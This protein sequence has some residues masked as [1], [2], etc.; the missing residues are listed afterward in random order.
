VGRSRKQG[1]A[2]IGAALAGAAL[3]LPAPASAASACASAG[4]QP[5][6]ASKHDVANATLCLL[7]AQRTRRGL[8]PLRANARLSRAARGHAQDMARRNYF[9][10]TSLSGASF[11]DRIRRSGYLR[12]ARS[13]SAGENIAWG[14]GRLARPREVV[15]AWMRSPGHRANI[16]NRRFRHIGLG[17]AFDAPVRRLGGATYVH[18]FGSRG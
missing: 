2:L 9:S 6:S 12:G 1:A 10:H 4:A 5:G 11:L 16:L 17:V 15:R 14:S 7:N 13:W 3:T 18:T 8:R